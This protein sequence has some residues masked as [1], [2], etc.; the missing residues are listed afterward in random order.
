[1]KVKIKTIAAESLGVRAYANYIETP[2]IKV[3]IDPGCA[4]GP[5]NK[6]K[7]PHPIEYI[8]LKEKT[9]E[10]IQ[11]SNK[12]DIL[13]ISHYHNDH[14]KNFVVDYDYI[15]TDNEIA[16][17]I[18][19]NKTIIIK[20]PNKFINYSQKKRAKI[21]LSHAKKIC[22]KIIIADNN[23]IAYGQTELNFSEPIFHGEL[24]STRGW[25]IM[26]LISYNNIEKFIFTSDIQG[27]ITKKPMNFI[28]TYS[29]DF[30]FLDAPSSNRINDFF[31]QNLKKLIKNTKKIII[32]HHLLRNLKWKKWINNK[33]GS[34][35]SNVFCAAEFNNKK[36]LQLEALRKELFVKYPPSDEFIKWTNLSQK[37]R[38]LTNPPLEKMDKN[39]QNTFIIDINIDKKNNDFNQ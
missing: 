28:S 9:N 20:D 38:K 13:I 3:L 32:D 17:K 37:I 5:K 39:F 29:P 11:Y 7:I 25:V 23:K 21:F 34:N 30:I 36:L 2:D 15:N 27:P 31:T 6:S 24:N 10:I 22:D 33:V 8:K 16:E 35:I 4:L 12:A 14:F 1:M 18:F 26:T 19:S